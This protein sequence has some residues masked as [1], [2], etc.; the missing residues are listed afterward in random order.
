MLRSASA[1]TGCTALP[2]R[3]ERRYKCPLTGVCPL[4]RVCSRQRRRARFEGFEVPSKARLPPAL[5]HTSDL[6][7]LTL[8]MGASAP[9]S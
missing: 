3:P 6:L 4:G 9:M 5:R 7:V 8:L 1:A 2:T